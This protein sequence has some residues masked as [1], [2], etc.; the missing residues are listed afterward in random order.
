MLGKG[1]VFFVCF[2]FFGFFFFALAHLV[3]F[4]LENY[5]VLINNPFEVLGDTMKATGYF[6][7]KANKTNKNKN[8]TASNSLDKLLLVGNGGLN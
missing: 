4:L 1:L 6:F 5:C 3:S 8:R 7:T 2:I